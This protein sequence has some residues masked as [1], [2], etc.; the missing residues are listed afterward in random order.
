MYFSEWRALTKIYCAVCEFHTGF[1]FNR[2]AEL[3]L[4][5]IVKKKLVD[6]LEKQGKSGFSIFSLKNKT[7]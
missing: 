3:D 4:N 6:K 2:L 7:I 5:R 1:S